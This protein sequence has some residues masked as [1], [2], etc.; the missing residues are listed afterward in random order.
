VSTAN[1]TVSTANE[2]VTEIQNELKKVKA[3]IGNLEAYV[4]SVVDNPTKEYVKQV[5]DEVSKQ[6]QKNPFAPSFDDFN[7]LF[8]KLKYAV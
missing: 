3:L 7:I 2:A 5:T 8:M 4:G 1:E 6:I